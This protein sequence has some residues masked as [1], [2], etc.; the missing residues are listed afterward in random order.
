[1]WNN[2]PVRRTPTILLALVLLAPVLSAQQKPDVGGS[3]AK[4]RRRL[5]AYR[6]R[7]TTEM[8]VD[9]VPRILK[10]ED[11][12]LGPDGGLVKEKTVRFEKQPP[13]TP[14]PY[15]DPRAKLGPPSTGMEDEAL[16]EQGQALM[17]LYL[18]LPPERLDEW[19]KG[20]EVLP[21]DPDRPGLVRIHGRGLARELDDTV[22]FLDGKTRAPVEIEVKTTLSDEVRDIAFLRVHI[23]PL[24]PP[25]PDGETL[26]VPRRIEMNIDRGRRHASF[27][28]TMS[29]FR[30]WP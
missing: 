1:M 29:D 23:G 13:P 11:V 22:L 7:L 24:S 2:P 18:R 5:S 3:V 25:P 30:T 4:E 8:S 16:F 14:L 21:P 15:N 17:Q 26:L 9:G 19:G 20:A 12:H 27:E 6:W 28:M 10:A